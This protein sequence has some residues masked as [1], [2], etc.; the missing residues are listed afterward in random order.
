MERSVSARK[1]ERMSVGIYDAD[2]A[3]YT[4]VPFNLTAM[5]LSAYY[6]KQREMVLFAKE[7]DPSRSKQCF[8]IKDWDDGDFPSSLDT[9]NITYLGHA[10]SGE[11]YIPLD[12]KIERCIPDTSIYSIM[13]PIIATETIRNKT[14]F[15]LMLNGEH[16]RISLDGKTVWPQYMCQFRDLERTR[17]IMIHDYDLGQV[18][19]AFEAV[20]HIMSLTKRNPT[21]G[22]KFP[23]QLTR[24]QDLMNWSS[25]HASPIFYSMGYSGLIPF[26]DFLNW[27]SQ[28]YGRNAYAMLEYNIMPK[29]FTANDFTEDYLRQILRQ[30]IISRSY[31]L[32]I[33]LIYDGDLLQD[34][35]DKQIL[36]LLNYYQHSM[37]DSFSNSAFIRE[38]QNDTVF[39]FAKKSLDSYG[40][41]PKMLNRYDM[42]GLFHYVQE[43]YPNLFREF[44]ELSYNKLKE[45]IK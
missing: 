38:I 34:I 36:D 30:V 6:K 42:R 31:C 1:G 5:K 4:L 44:Y 45:E 43:H 27:C 16:C 26:D 24:P 2:M 29:S 9:P 8:Y 11:R 22:L 14:L 37:F 18:D 12:E 41:Y 32:K 25:F 21:L 40:K 10:F 28:G 20:Q 39:D 13:E 7:F 17:H 15:S 23:P 19:G 33:S 35:H 3:K